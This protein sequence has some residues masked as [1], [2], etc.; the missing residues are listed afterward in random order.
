MANTKSAKKMIRVSAR[1]RT[2]NKP[3]RS[4]T[5]TFVSKAEKLILQKDIE[6]ASKAVLEAVSTLDRAASKG[7][8][9]RNNAARRKSRLTKKL[10]AAL[11][12]KQ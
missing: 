12:T 3:I 1:K 6:G 9:H 5:K 4:A 11:A 10:N 2:R 8:I 7:N